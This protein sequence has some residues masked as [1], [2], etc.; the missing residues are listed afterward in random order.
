MTM[1]KVHRNFFKFIKKDLEFLGGFSG[2]FSDFLLKKG[3]FWDVFRSRKTSQNP[4]KSPKIEIFLGF[5]TAFVACVCG[6][7][8][9]FYPPPFDPSSRI[10]SA[11][12]LP[13]CCR[14]S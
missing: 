12:P 13:S 4:K 10:L 3:G 5:I 2:T 1:L 9:F 6:C 11:P 14:I 8:H 7:P